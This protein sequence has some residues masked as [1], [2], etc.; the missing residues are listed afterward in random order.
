MKRILLIFIAAHSTFAM[1]PQ[2][3]FDNPKK[4]CAVAYL[5][6]KALAKSCKGQLIGTCHQYITEQFKDFLQ[7]CSQERRAKVKMCPEEIL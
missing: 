4:E 1:E 7:K 2:P 6:F 5:E 3:L